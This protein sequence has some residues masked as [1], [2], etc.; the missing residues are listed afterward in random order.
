MTPQIAA[1]LAVIDEAAFRLQAERDRIAGERARLLALRAAGCIAGGPLICAL[2]PGALRT[3]ADAS[4]AM[5]EAI[6]TFV[7]DRLPRLEAAAR[8][9]D[10]A[11]AG[12]AVEAC[13][14]IVAAAGGLQPF[15]DLVEDASRLVVGIVR[16]LERAAKPGIDAATIVLAIVGIYGVSR[17]LR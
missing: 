3:R 7:A 1:A 16:D 14:R 10:A 6:E 4:L 15:G 11:A 5:I 17:L 12:R 8:A 13:R 9:G 2:D